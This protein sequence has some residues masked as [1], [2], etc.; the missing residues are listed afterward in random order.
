MGK[1]LGEMSPAERAAVIKRAA[2]R[3]QAELQASAPAIGRILDDADSHL[4]TITCCVEVDIYRPPREST[5]P[6]CHSVFVAKTD[7]R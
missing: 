7:G 3:L 1:T 4:Y 6:V 5:C 2:D